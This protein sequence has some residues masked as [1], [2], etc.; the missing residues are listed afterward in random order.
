MAICLFVSGFSA[1]CASELGIGQPRYLLREGEYPAN[2]SNPAPK[3]TTTD[4]LGLE[5]NPGKLGRSY[6]ENHWQYG[7]PVPQDAW[8][9]FF[10]NETDGAALSEVTIWV[11]TYAS[12]E[13]ARLLGRSACP[14]AIF[15]WN[16]YAPFA[17]FRD[18]KTLILIEQSHRGP[19]IE[20]E[21]RAIIDAELAKNPDIDVVCA[22]ER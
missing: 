15:G 8:L 3:Q 18:D 2:L 19:T 9:Q 7:E 12:E 6:V 20:W 11:A 21:W 4:E 13:D 1:G 22:P 5:T 10:R 14:L 16:N 17:V